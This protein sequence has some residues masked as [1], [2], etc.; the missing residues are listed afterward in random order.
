MAKANLPTDFGC[1]ELS[2]YHDQQ[3][4]EKKDHIVLINGAVKLKEGVLV[5]IH[6]ECMTGDV[7]GSMR[8]DCGDQ[9]HTALRLISKEQEGILIY[10]R[11]EGRG[12]GL[13][14]K[15]FTYGLQELG[16]DT[17]AA[18]HILGFPTD[19]RD[20]SIAVGILEDLGVKSI[21][22][23]TNNPGKVDVFSSSKIRCV[24]RV[25]LEIQSNRYNKKY[26]Q[27]K[28]DIT[29]HFLKDD[30]LASAPKNDETIKNKIELVGFFDK[31]KLHFVLSNFGGKGHYSNQ[32]GDKGD[33]SEITYQACKFTYIK[34]NLA[35]QKLKQHYLS[36]ISTPEEAFLFMKEKRPEL[37]NQ[38][39]NDDIVKN[40]WE[41]LDLNGLPN[42]DTEMMHCLVNKFDPIDNPDIFKELIQTVPSESRILV[43]ESAF[44]SYWG[45]KKNNDGSPGRN[46][47]GLMLTAIAR[48]SFDNA[49]PGL[50]ENGRMSK[51]MAE[52]KYLLQEFEGFDFHDLHEGRDSGTNKTNVTTLKNGMLSE[53]QDNIAD[54]FRKKSQQYYDSLKR[55]MFNLKEKIHHNISRKEIGL[56]KKTNLFV[57]VSEE[58]FGKICQSARLIKIKKGSSQF[59]KHKSDDIF[60]IVSEG[61]VAMHSY[62]KYLYNEQEET[63]SSVKLVRGDYFSEQLNPDD[64]DSKFHSRTEAISDVTLIQI[65]LGVSTINP[66]EQPLLRKISRGIIHEQFLVSLKSI[67]SLYSALKPL[68]FPTKNVSII[69]IENNQLVLNSKEQTRK[70]YII[71]RGAAKIISDANNNDNFSCLVLHEG[72][73]IDSE[74]MA[75]DDLPSFSIIAEGKLS[76]LSIE[77][78]KAITHLLQ[79]QYVEKVIKEVNDTP[80]FG[81]IEQNIGSVHNKGCVITYLYKLNNGRSIV[82]LYNLDLMIFIMYVNDVTGNEFSH[83]KSNKNKINLSFSDN[84]L[85]RI[86]I[87]GAWEER[88]ALCALL[89]E[90]TFIPSAAIEQ[91]DKTGLLTN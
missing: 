4:K 24:D 46:R 12:I 53:F 34:D 88:P 20:F 58:T 8:C 37:D 2:I 65:D 72:H 21:R 56:L 18:N 90:N 76:L 26:L 69:E 45:Y 68:L 64:K 15:I 7:F 42:K 49:W 79:N 14:N 39:I 6:S 57:G 33:Y 52:Y 43:E 30:M 78:D 48:A 59:G 47:L 70:F 25:P 35:S 91:F 9:L 31:S 41:S 16:I 38:S 66:D 86:V 29:G 17:V 44:D 87:F 13:L 27:V 50:T 55:S 75:W 5:R 62:R 28:R 71:L 84:R 10:L 61:V 74:K 81:R 67:P 11:Q 77:Q 32:Y 3:D 1:F 22:L 23:L 89:L 63:L 83:F 60:Y 85:N 19:M 54:F 40:G 36:N 82:S 80:L 51:V 73:V